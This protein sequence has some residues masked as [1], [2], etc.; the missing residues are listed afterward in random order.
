MNRIKKM[1]KASVE[2]FKAWQDLTKETTPDAK[3]VSDAKAAYEVAQK[4][5]E[6]A[7]EALPDD[8]AADPARVASEEVAELIKSSV[9]SGLKAALPEHLA[10]QLT[11]ESVK[12]IVGDALAAHAAAAKTDADKKLTNEALT[13][14]VGESIK[15]AIESLKGSSRGVSLLEGGEAGKGGAQVEVATSWRKGNLPLHGKQLLNILLR[16][17]VNEGIDK[18]DLTKGAKYDDQMWDGIQ[19]QGVKALT[20]TGTGTGVELIPR[21]L[22]SELYRR[23]YLESALAQS[24]LAQEVQ[25]PTDPYDY[26]LLTTDPTFY[27]NNVENVAPPASDPGTSK[28]TLTTENIMALVQ[29]SYK[30]D[31]DSIV[32]ILP[33]LQF[34]LARAAARALENAIINGDTTAT[35]MDTGSTVAANDVLRCWKGFRKLALAVSALK[36]DLTSGGLNRANLLGV[37]KLLGKYGSR[38]Q[39]ILWVVGPRGWT[40]LLGLDEVAFAYARGATGS[41]IAGGPTPAPWGGQIVVSEMAREDLNAV[42]VW[43]NSTTTKGAI[44]AVNRAQFVM[45]S[46]RDFMV[47]VDRN[48]KSQTHDI[49]ASFRKAFQPVETPSATVPSVAIGYDYVS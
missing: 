42:G 18:A 33:T 19:A 44:I 17:N 23:M 2:A 4:S 24:F 32:P 12:K 49:V 8:P 5:Y 13:K 22:S 46:R 41:Y 27:R 25:M 43:D 47:E 34:T 10:S 48:I 38:T 45:G 29:Y 39:D 35:H 21:S 31:E 40:A 26:P 30:A 1:K 20:T 15:S 9:Q 3:K 28:F 7:V 36:S 14:I 6:D 37:L 11:E 16:R